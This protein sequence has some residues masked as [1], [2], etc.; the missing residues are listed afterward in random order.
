M[1][2]RNYNFQ[3]FRNFN[4]KEFQSNISQ[5]NNV[6]GVESSFADPTGLYLLVSGLIINRLGYRLVRLDR[7]DRNNCRLVRLNI[8]M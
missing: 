7:L 8:F 1:D 6:Y 2:F 5:F 3:S 4:L